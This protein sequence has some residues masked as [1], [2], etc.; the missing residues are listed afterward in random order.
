MDEN[1]GLIWYLAKVTSE[2]FFFIY[3]E[4]DL[5]YEDTRDTVQDDEQI[6]F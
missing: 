5:V 1:D 6:P 4:S 2:E 3:E